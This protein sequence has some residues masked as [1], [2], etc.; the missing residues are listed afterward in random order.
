MN[1]NWPD[2]PDGGWHE[3]NNWL[4]RTKDIL[5]TT[6]LTRYLDGVK[7]VTDELT[8]LCES[9][10]MTYEMDFEAR[11]VG[12][13]AAHFLIRER[14][15]VPRLKWNTEVLDVAIEIQIATTV[16]GVVRDLLHP[17]YER[18]RLALEAPDTKWQWDYRSDEFAANYI[19][20]MSHYLDGMIMGVRDRQT[21]EAE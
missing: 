1:E 12:Y 16:H 11:E 7:L 20:H 6:V 17:Y 10:S 9:H 18:Q 8:E 19:G 13:Y 3:P 21:E 15:E 14:V 5:R 2:E 4:Y